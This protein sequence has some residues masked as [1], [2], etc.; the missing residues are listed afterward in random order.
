M[1]LGRC[2]G[3]A[4]GLKILVESSRP[5][6]STGT[7][8]RGGLW[9]ESSRSAAGLP[10]SKDSTGVMPSSARTLERTLLDDG[11]TRD[12]EIMPIARRIAVGL[13]LR[14]VPSPTAIAKK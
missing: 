8:I 6:I 7:I 13:V 14:L 5:E 1:I 2:A 9:G 3:V 10:V 4:V 12:G 11:L